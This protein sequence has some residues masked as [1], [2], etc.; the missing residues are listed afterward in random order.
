MDAPR[1]VLKSFARDYVELPENRLDSRC[2]GGGGHL[3]SVNN[4]LRM[5]VVK[6]RLNQV[7]EAGARILTSGC[8]ACKL[9]FVDGVREEGLDIEVMDLVELV[10]RQLNHH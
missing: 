7:K 9:A 1:Q 4:P 3:Q 5:A 10:A 8:P 2:C 6:H